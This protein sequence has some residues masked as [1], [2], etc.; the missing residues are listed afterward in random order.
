MV[1]G[2][3]HTQSAATQ[4]PAS[5]GKPRWFTNRL[6][7]TAAV[8]ERVDF[9]RY[10]GHTS[11]P[12]NSNG[13]KW[14]RDDMLEEIYAAK[15]REVGKLRQ[16]RQRLD[17]ELA[18]R[19]THRQYA[20][21]RDELLTWLQSGECGLFTGAHG[22]IAVKDKELDRLIEVGGEELVD[23]TGVGGM[24]QVGCGK[25]FM[26]LVRRVNELGMR[27][28]S[29]KA[30][31]VAMR[32]MRAE[33]EA[34]VAQVVAAEPE[35]E[36][37][38]T[39]E[40]TQAEQSAPEVEQAEEQPAE[41][42]AQPQAAEKP[43]AASEAETTEPAAVEPEQPATPTPQSATEEE[44]EAPKPETP[45]AKPAD[46]TFVLPEDSRNRQHSI[47]QN[48]SLRT[49]SAGGDED[50]TVEQPPP[51]QQHA[52]HNT[53]AEGEQSGAATEGEK[54]SVGSLM[55]KL[56]ELEEE[57]EGEGEETETKAEAAEEEFPQSDETA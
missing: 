26:V 10:S 33:L 9:T 47:S 44:E 12:D 13:R 20:A 23:W 57:Q 29:F 35:A 31:V 51:Q 46:E 14:T 53:M 8:D 39:P 17:L 55:E 32:M 45:A 50:G 56:A 4:P 2:L 41:E 38:P 52:R 22:V 48:N 7:L 34:A 43:E 27:F 54:L 5:S 3:Y 42:A 15:R 24:E 1:A 49:D 30:L 28:E 11:L 36:E 37:E 16:D 21:S 25:R 18:H 40:T 6:T 19:H